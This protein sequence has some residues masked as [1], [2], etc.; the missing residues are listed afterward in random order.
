M[1]TEDKLPRRYD[2]TGRQAAAA[3]RR[4]AV[5]AAARD[6]FE[7]AGW[8]GTTMRQVA[9][10]SGVSQ[11]TIEAAFRTKAA[12]L[13]AA[14]DYAIRGDVD[15]LPVPRRASVHAMERAADA[16]EMLRLHARHLR[17]I[18]GRSAAVAGVVEQAAASDPAVAKL[19]RRMNRNRVYGVRWAAETLLRK[20]GRRP[21]LRRP[22]VESVF[23]VALDWG[24]YRTLTRQAHLDDDAYE[25]W[26]R[27]Y[28]ESM[29][30]PPSG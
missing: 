21:R 29:L 23:W 27:A 6:A 26:L 4:L 19:W 17:A 22:Y 5:V 1:G 24:T 13:G 25:A 7:R 9:E 11:K 18:N 3:E 20:P 10:A 8:A 28:Y 15:P 14:V 12:L 30:L 16:R 2:S